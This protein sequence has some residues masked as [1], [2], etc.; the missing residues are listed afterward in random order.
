MSV[1]IDP[2]NTDQLRA[3][4]GA[5]GAFWA[6]EAELFEHALHRYDHSLLRAAGILPGNKVLDVGCGTGSLTRAV[7]E[8]N[9]PGTAL[10]VDLSSPMVAIASRSAE[11]A[12]LRNVE[13][14]QADAQVYPFADDEFDVVVSRTGSMFFADQLA[15]FE[16][17]ARTTRPGGRLALLSWRSAA[18]NEWFT[19]LAAALSAGRELPSPPAG[20]P[21]PFSH[22][23]T[24]R[25]TEVLVAAG[26]DKPS[27]EALDEP[28]YFGP[29]VPTAERFVLG[30]LGW[31]V[32]G[33]DDE[34]RAQA[35][36]AL[37]ID[38]QTHLT[39]EG[40]AYASSAWLIGSRAV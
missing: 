19:S 23:D 33:L 9:H 11:V 14:L 29:D 36:E 4:D 22:A 10:G 3:W 21:G 2:G 34:T 15:A 12:G 35:L 7:A 40:V 26:F 13:F 27:F 16:N 5:E 6:A 30:V 31:L 32:D 8:R 37:R 25:V 39:A 28:M 24:A 38:L 17:L 18:E 20:A 1:R